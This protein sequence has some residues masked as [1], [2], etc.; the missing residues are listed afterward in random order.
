MNSI[1]DFKSY[2]ELKIKE[3]EKLKSF[4]INDKKASKKI[5]ITRDLLLEIKQDFKEEITRREQ[6][7]KFSKVEA[8][9][10][11]NK[12]LK[13]YPWIE[14]LHKH[15]SSAIYWFKIKSPSRKFN[16]NVYI[17]V[18]DFRKKT[19]K[20]FSQVESSRFDKE[21]DVLYIGKVQSQLLNRF[22]QHIGLGHKSTTSLQM[23]HWATDLPDFELEYRFLPIEK[24]YFNLLEDIEVVMWNHHSPLLGQGKRMKKEE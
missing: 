12:L 11:K 5:V 19:K 22:I 4:S 10:L 20:W 16:D 9:N 14:P 15:N 21:K 17:R 6:D 8:K 2:A 18:K 7:I 13:K 3:Y 23:L 24:K 1:P